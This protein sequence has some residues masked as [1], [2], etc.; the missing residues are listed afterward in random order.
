MQGY[1]SIRDAADYA[2]VS[3]R[4]VKRWVHAGLPVYQGCHRG[5]VLIKPSDIDTYLQRKTAPKVDLDTMVDEVLQGIS[6]T[7][8]EVGG[9]PARS[10]AQRGRLASR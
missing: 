6:P 8:A 7:A 4:T 10:L 9:P 3:T 2:S 1:V 5:K